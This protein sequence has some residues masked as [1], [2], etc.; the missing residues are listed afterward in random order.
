[1]NN[2]PKVMGRWLF[3]TYRCYICN[4]KMNFHQGMK[5]DSERQVMIHKACERK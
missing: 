5:V 1:M 2:F 4:Q 3:H